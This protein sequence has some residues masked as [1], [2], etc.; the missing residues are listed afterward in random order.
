MSLS[1]GMSSL[2]DVVIRS[3][4]LE[5]SLKSIDHCMMRGGH[6]HMDM[7]MDIFHVVTNVHEYINVYQELLPYPN[8]HHLAGWLEV[9]FFFFFF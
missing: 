2:L 1:A 5:M 6:P 4:N 3:S 9:L 8:V 7:D